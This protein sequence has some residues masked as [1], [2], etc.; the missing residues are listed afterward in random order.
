MKRWL[1]TLCI[2]LVL[3]AG[4]LMSLS[5]QQRENVKAVKD[6]VSYTTEE[7]EEKIAE[8]QQ[9]IR[10]AVAAVPE[11]SVREVT[12]EE[13][14]ALRDGALTQEELVEYLMGTGEQAETPAGIG[15]PPALKESG[16]RP[17]ERLP[18]K[19]AGVTS[20]AEK[21]AKTEHA[22]PTARK[23]LESAYQ[24]ELS[25]IVARVYVLREEYT[26]TLDNMYE[27]AKAEYI[28]MSAEMRTK[29]DLVKM[30]GRYLDQA[31]ALEREC[32]HQM[33][34]I[35]I[36][37]ENLIKENE[38]DMSLV[39]TVVDTYAREKSLKKS[40]YMSKLAERGLI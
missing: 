28:D 24:K 6:A 25:A 39:D 11:I 36:E 33:D 2:V 8:N 35:V 21:P 7:L 34:A 23:P 26:M 27:A 29:S 13:R 1:K 17:A 22:A 15:A 12:A 5:W 40:W 19:Q 9:M 32:D 38:G 4:S 20:G 10:N 31:T 16:Q 37:M 14:Q 3:L 18:E 30:A